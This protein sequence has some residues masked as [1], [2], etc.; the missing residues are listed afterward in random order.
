MT[1]Q[2]VQSVHETGRVHRTNDLPQHASGDSIADDNNL[3]TNLGNNNNLLDGHVVRARSHQT[4]GLT[5][6]DYA[7]QALVEVERMR[8]YRL[9]GQLEEKADRSRRKRQGEILVDEV[10]WLV[11]EDRV[12]REGLEL[13]GNDWP[14]ISRGLKPRRRTPHECRERIAQLAGHP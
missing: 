12:L 9:S 10:E 6:Y 1:Q 4:T 7:V 11:E 2:V 3:G 13:F 5:S 8:M 14:R